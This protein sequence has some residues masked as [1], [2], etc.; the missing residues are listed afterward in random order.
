MK[1]FK[2]IVPNILI[3]LDD[4]LL[5]NKPDL[6]STRLHWVLWYSLIFNLLITFLA[7]LTPIDFLRT[8]SA[9]YWSVFVSII[10]FIAFI[11]W[12]I[13]LLQFNVFKHFG[14]FSALSN[15]KLFIAYFICISCFVIYPFIYSIVEV[16]KTNKAY[17]STELIN[18]IN[19]VNYNIA[20][21]E[22]DSLPKNW[23]KDTV[24]VIAKLYHDNTIQNDSIQKIIQQSKYNVIDSSTFNFRK[25]NTDSIISL[26][27]HVYVIIDCPQ[28][29]TLNLFYTNKE[30]NLQL[31]TNQSIYNLIF[32]NYKAPPKDS[33]HNEL[34]NIF[35]KY[36]ANFS[37]NYELDTYRNDVNLA[38]SLL[39]A[40]EIFTKY[41][42]SGVERG[43]ENIFRKKNRWND[44]SRTD[45]YRVVIY[46]SLIL[47][48]F[49]F[50]FRNTTIK[51]FFLTLLVSLLL[52]IISG[53]LIAMFNLKFYA[54]YI[55]CIFYTLLFMLMALT[56]FFQKSRAIITGI[57]INI[58][59]SIF[60]FFPIVIVWFYYD[61][62]RHNYIIL[63][64]NNINYQTVNLHFFY[65][66]I[67]MLC[68]LL[69]LIPTLIFRM[70]KKW[71]ALPDN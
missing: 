18:D 43:L 9:D 61:W 62:H 63:N 4:W 58:F 21:L 6:W 33:L 39:T 48:L 12:L 70:Y 14:I 27:N 57:A 49:V 60:A 44:E 64:N 13:Y 53:L 3:K 51:T 26:G 5:K 22:H 7:C 40:H 8:S 34:K 47:A 1:V 50:I 56:V 52:T 31:L 20:W 54:V 67:V 28:Y 15:L 10:S 45:A 32:K 17:N 11:I 59:T 16:V 2:Y 65:A 42:L 69:F 35:K 25:Q 37:I 30:E 46:I 71:Y 36:N 66:E 19:K 29:L 24:F 41:N 55:F 38:D 68:L 23:Q